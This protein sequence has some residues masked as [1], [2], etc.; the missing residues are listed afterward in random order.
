MYEN[1]LTE[2]LVQMVNH[3]TYHRGNVTAMLYQAGLPSCGTDWILFMREQ[4]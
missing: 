1:T 3:G 4:T 2:L